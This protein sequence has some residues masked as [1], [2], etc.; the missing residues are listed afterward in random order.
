MTWPKK[1]ARVGKK[2]DEAIAIEAFLMMTDKKNMCFTYKSEDDAKKKCSTIRSYRR[3]NNHKELYD[4]MR[5]DNCIYIIR[6]MPDK[7][8]K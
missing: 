2:S 1:K 6:I 8:T 5:S 7:K 4:V 3:T